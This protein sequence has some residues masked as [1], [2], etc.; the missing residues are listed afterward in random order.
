MNAAVIS[1]VHISEQLYSAD[2]VW[3]KRFCEV[4]STGCRILL[5]EN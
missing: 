1:L 5:R 4:T 3:L 2:G